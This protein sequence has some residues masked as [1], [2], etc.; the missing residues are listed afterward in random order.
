MPWSNA[1]LTGVFVVPL[2]ASVAVGAT[3]VDE[4]GCVPVD[5]VGVVAPAVLDEFAYPVQRDG[6]TPVPGLHFLG[7]N[8]VDRRASGI[9]YGIG[10]DAEQAATVIRAELAGGRLD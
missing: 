10:E 5:T 2:P 7:L 8:Y 3:S 9:L 4:G 6:K 1:L